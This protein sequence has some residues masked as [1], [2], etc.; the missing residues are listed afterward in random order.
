MYRVFCRRMTLV[1]EDVRLRF[2]LYCLYL[3]LSLK[4]LFSK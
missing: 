2:P 4:T 3:S 1:N